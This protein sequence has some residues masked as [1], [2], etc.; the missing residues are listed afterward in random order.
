MT[1]LR[2]FIGAGLAITI[3][4]TCGI[5]AMAESQ[6]TAAQPFSLT[7]VGP[8]LDAGTSPASMAVTPNGGTAYVSNN[9]DGGIKIIDL[10]GKKPAGRV[11]IASAGTD[12][13][14]SPDGSMI[15]VYD[16][17][18]R[19]LVGISTVTN[20][21]TAVGGLP[22]KAYIHSL[23]VSPDGRTLL[24]MG[25][26]EPAVYVFDATSLEFQERVQLD[27][28]LQTEGVWITPDSSEAYI[29]SAFPFAVSVMDL[30]TRKIV[31]TISACS[32]VRGIVFTPNG[33]KAYVGCQSGHVSVVSTVTG[34]ETKVIEP[35]FKVDFARITGDGA[36]VLVSGYSDSRLAE[37]D[38]ATD[39]VTSTV[40]LG[41]PP[42]DLAT[43]RS[44]TTAFV[45]TS[46][47][48]GGGLVSP[49][50]VAKG[51]PSVSTDRLFGPDR[52]ST[53]V[54]VSQA[55]FWTSGTVYVATGEQFPDALAAAPAAAKEDAPLLLTKSSILPN[56][57][58]DEI[59]RLKPTKI[60]VV[61]GPG[62]VSAAVVKQLQTIV[63]GT[64]RRAGAD[65]YATARAVVAG[66]FVGSNPAPMSVALA[67]GANY[68]DA[69]SAAT[70]DPVLLVPPGTKRLDAATMALL[71]SMH[72][73]K[74]DIVGGTGVI[75]ASIEKPLLDQFIQVYRYAGKDRFETNQ[76]LNQ[77]K[78]PW[79]ER[80]YYAAGYNFPDAL[81]IAAVAPRE[82]GLVYL[83]RPN[84]ISAAILHDLKGTDAA[85][86]ITLV[87]GPGVVGN[88]VAARKQ[89]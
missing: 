25:D 71:K 9:V 52:Y 73:F 44:S 68:P 39:S 83:V 32:Y 8:D 62:A 78:A 63:P 5:P 70:S 67:T 13:V 64:I 27:P 19:L 26:Y 21:V 72:V 51:N 89:C 82:Q 14:A 17:G 74:A 58:R 81:A 28:N 56:V 57:V 6:P 18:A 41:G 22:L 2:S 66:A 84:C 77:S 15:Y 60:V 55:S 46:S 23:T 50:T 36:K 45:L 24:A 4:V 1:L 54:A 11:S 76:K 88:E 47:E 85:R 30:A 87:G 35:G 10:A 61:G 43:S 16:R 7:A 48:S 86:R 59:L 29:S 12:P 40:S 20:T 53:A 34:K 38:V 79:N 65:R 49:V 69:L 37:I 42:R 33:Q 31:K 3:S 75:P 80:I